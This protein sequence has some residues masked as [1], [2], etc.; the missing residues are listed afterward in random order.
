M[1]KNGW[2]WLFVILE[3]PQVSHWYNHKRQSCHDI[4]T[5][6]SDAFQQ[7]ASFYGIEFTDEMADQ[8]DRMFDEEDTVFEGKPPYKIS[9]RIDAYSGEQVGETYIETPPVSGIGYT[10]IVLWK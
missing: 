7:R 2:K 9:I 4:Y 3:V 5:M 1:R 6:A 8:F 10:G